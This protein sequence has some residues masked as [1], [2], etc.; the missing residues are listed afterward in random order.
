MH[1]L[2]L[3]VDGEQHNAGVLQTVYPSFSNPGK[4]YLYTISPRLLESFVPAVLKPFR[5]GVHYPPAADIDATT[6]SLN[7]T[8]RRSTSTVTIAINITVSCT[9]VPRMNVLG[10]WGG[11]AAVSRQTCVVVAPWA[12]TEPRSAAK[13]KPPLLGRFRRS[14]GDSSTRCCGWLWGCCSVASSHWEIPNMRR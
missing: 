6:R 14:S 9:N 7:S 10:R 8:L 3:E 12:L 11:V 1:D 5:V 4:K 2:E 13:R